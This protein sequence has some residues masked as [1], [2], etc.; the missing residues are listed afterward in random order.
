MSD[1]QFHQPSKMTAN[2]TQD[3]IDLVI[4]KAD[5]LGEH[6]VARQVAWGVA[7]LERLELRQVREN[8]PFVIQPGEGAA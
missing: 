7:E 6:Y 4:A 1:G 8:G 5:Q 2:D 3:Y